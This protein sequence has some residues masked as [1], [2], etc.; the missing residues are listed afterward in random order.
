MQ[1]ESNTKRITFFFIAEC[2]LSYQKIMQIESNTKRIAFFF[3][4]ECSFIV[5]QIE[6]VFYLL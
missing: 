3:I 2:S 4:A 5:L 6:G 1:I